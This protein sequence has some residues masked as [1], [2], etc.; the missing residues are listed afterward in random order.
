[1]AFRRLPRFVIHRL[2]SP[3]EPIPYLAL[4]RIEGR[5]FYVGTWSDTQWDLSPD[6]DRPPD[7]RRLDGG[8]M[9]VRPDEPPPP[10]DSYGRASP[11][12]AIA[13]TS[14]GE[15]APGT[16]VPRRSTASGG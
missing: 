4:W 9:V 13:V 6:G 10:A 11:T 5:N 16:S 2:D 3:A 14:P 1:M 12:D 15:P 8:W 7:A